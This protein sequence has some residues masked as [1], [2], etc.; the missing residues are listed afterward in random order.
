LAFEEDQVKI[1][2]LK[3]RERKEIKRAVE[4]YHEAAVNGATGNKNRSISSLC[5]VDA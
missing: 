2:K 3:K 1:M 4:Y 5:M